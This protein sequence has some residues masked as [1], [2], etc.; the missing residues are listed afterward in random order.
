MLPSTIQTLSPA[1]NEGSKSRAETYD[2]GYKAGFGAGIGVGAGV[3]AALAVVV[4]ILWVAWM[5]RLPCKGTPEAQTGTM[6]VTSVDEPNTD[7]R[8]AETAGATG[9][10]YELR[11]TDIGLK[12]PYAQARN[13]E[14]AGATGPFYELRQN[15]IGLTSAFVQASI[16]ETA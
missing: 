2:D 9:P 7:S 12:S 11:Q 3:L 1:V 16:T 8:P 14:T 10:Y 5:R 15:E 13:T 4:V 6:S